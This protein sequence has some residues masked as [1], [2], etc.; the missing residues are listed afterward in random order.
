MSIENTP[1]NN[2]VPNRG[3]EVARILDISEVSDRPTTVEFM[4]LEGTSGADVLATL[5]F[6]Q[7]DKKRVEEHIATLLRYCVEVKGILDRDTIKIEENLGDA[8]TGNVAKRYVEIGYI[9]TYEDLEATVMALYSGEDLSEKLSRLFRIFVDR[10]AI[11][12]ATV[13]ATQSNE[14][15]TAKDEDI[16]TEMVE[17]I[18]RFSS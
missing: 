8:A 2:G 9:S 18:K 12:G 10:G 3:P 5:N 14:I 7:P 16:E 4:I 6:L 11:N 13:R 15:V 1:H 17:L